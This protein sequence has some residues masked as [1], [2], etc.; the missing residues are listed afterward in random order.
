[1]LRHR[2]VRIVARI[3]FVVAPALLPGAPRELAEAVVGGCTPA[4]DVTA[5]RQLPSRKLDWC[6][7]AFSRLRDTPRRR[8][9]A[10]AV[11]GVRR[12]LHRRDAPAVTAGLPRI[13][14]RLVEIVGQA[15]AVLGYERV[16]ID[17][18]RDAFARFV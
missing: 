12:H 11:G 18:L 13:A 4:I 17:Q 7:E 15:L 9:F 3:H 1:F 14:A 10:V 6:R 5:W 2:D 8:P 16:E